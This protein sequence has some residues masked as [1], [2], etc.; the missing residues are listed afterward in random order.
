MGL[1]DFSTAP[2]VTRQTERGQDPARRSRDGGLLL[3]E[4][5]ARRPAPRIGGRDRGTAM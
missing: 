1:K 2:D 3:P 4:P 5:V